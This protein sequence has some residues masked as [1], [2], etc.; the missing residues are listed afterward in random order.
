MLFCFSRKNGQIARAFLMSLTAVDRF[1][2]VNSGDQA[3]F[4]LGT[5]GYSS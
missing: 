3:F 2:Q 4:S 1:G 5:S